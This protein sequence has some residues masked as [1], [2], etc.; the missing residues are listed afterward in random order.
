MKRAANH[1]AA[2]TKQYWDILSNKEKE[3]EDKAQV[4]VAATVSNLVQTEEKSQE[5]TRQTGCKSS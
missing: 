4:S 2:L 1:L 3:K 5:K